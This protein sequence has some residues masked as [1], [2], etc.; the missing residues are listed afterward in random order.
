MTAHVKIAGAPRRPTSLDRLLA[1]S[2]GIELDRAYDRVQV[3][4]KLAAWLTDLSA[5]IAKQKIALA[6]GDLSCD[7]RELEREFERLKLAVALHKERR[8]GGD[9]EGEL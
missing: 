3:N 6:C 2:V 8:L 4:A 9:D 7:P 5:R 1:R